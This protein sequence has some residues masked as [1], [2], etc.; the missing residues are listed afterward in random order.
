MRSFGTQGRVRPERHYV[1]P[2]TEQVADFITRIRAGKYIVLFAPR[3]TGKTTFFRL[4]LDALRTE[5]PNFFP[6]QLNFEEYE[7]YTPSEFYGSLYEDIR[8][9]IENVFQKRGE[10]LDEALTQFLENTKLTDH[11]SMRRFFSRF[12]RLLKNQRVIVIIDEFDG[13]PQAAVKGF[14]HSLRYIYLSDELLCLHS[15]SIVGVKSI[16]QLDYDR[17]V[18]PFNIQDE[19]RLP[20]FTLEQVRDLLGQY[21]EEVGQTFAPE[22][23]ES[24]HKQTAGQ[25]FLV[26]RIAQILT[27]ELNIPKT[28]PLT[29]THFAQAYKQLLRERNTNIDHLRTNVRRDRRFEKMLLRIA[30]YE[31]G[32]RFNPDNDLMN[33]LVTYGI[34]GEGSDGM[35]EIA[36][37]IYQHHILQ[38]FQTVV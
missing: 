11:V 25:P 1:V 24:F 18:S 2:R 29:I 19:F 15:V 14:L 10:A 9:E 34:I 37:P 23:I 33:E 4:A 17:P 20:N 8:E 7:D 30:S 26:N 12:S 3:Q 13:I 32:M 27:A 28:E 31:K 6:I 21:T 36:N 5:A 38:V 35:C 22:V 16:T